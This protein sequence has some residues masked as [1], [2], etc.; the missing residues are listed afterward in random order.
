M[1]VKIVAISDLHGYLPEII[2][3]ADIMLIAGD[4]FPLNIQF[5]KYESQEWVNHEFSE[6]IKN[7]PVK[8][9]Y[10]VAGNHDSFFESMNKNQLKMMLMS[11]NN[12]L[13]YLENETTIHEIDNEHSITIFGTPYCHIFGRWPFMREE[14]YMSEKFK[15]IPNYCDIIISHDPPFDVNKCDCIL[16]DGHTYKDENK[17]LGNKPLTA[18]IN[19]VNYKLLV[20]GHIHSGEH[21]LVNKVTNVSYVDEF[22]QPVF[23]PFYTDIDVYC[24]EDDNYTE[25]LNN[26]IKDNFLIT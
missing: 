6:W 5:K 23:E 10:L 1:K 19:N 9:V 4:I 25:F 17:H 22:Y 21:Q 7:L 24:E 26:N 8:K 11:C 18:R 15:E 13:V 20:C 14:S 3:P 12:K 2:E 16:Q